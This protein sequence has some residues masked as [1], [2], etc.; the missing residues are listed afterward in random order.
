MPHFVQTV[1][2]LLIPQ[3]VAA[4]YYSLA[5]FEVVEAAT[6]EFDLEL[7]RGYE[8]GEAAHPFRHIVRNIRPDQVLES[9]VNN[10]VTMIYCEP[11]IELKKDTGEVNFKALPLKDRSITVQKYIDGIAEEIHKLR[12][13]IVRQKYNAYINTWAGHSGGVRW[14]QFRQAWD[15]MTAGDTLKYGAASDGQPFFDEN[16]PGADKDRNPAT[17]S[18]LFALPLNDN[19][20]DII[21]RS[22]L[23][24]RNIFGL[25]YGN[26][27]R[28][29]T[30]NA[31]Q[32][33]RGQVSGARPS[34]HLSVGPALAS[35]AHDLARFAVENPGKFAGSFT[36]ETISELSGEHENVWFLRF[37]DE[38]RAPLN[39]ID[40]GAQLIV[41]NG[42]DTEPGRLRGRTEWILR[43]AWGFTYDRWDCISMSKPE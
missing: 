27:W 13:P 6:V 23:E 21:T 38:R 28:S 43:A 41:R 7:D 30:A 10:Q 33:D 14:T 32:T 8:L 12:Q 20:V 40:S 4:D 3:N 42:Y 29:Y 31:V 5:D 24:Y 25:P 35:Q 16:H 36:W 17:Y 18:N 19:S 34:F 39:F 15:Y 9:P 2:G 37:L 26:M 11:D 22:M 1:Q